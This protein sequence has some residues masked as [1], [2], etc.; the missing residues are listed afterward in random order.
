MLKE[1][2][3]VSD[4]LAEAERDSRSGMA[5]TEPGEGTGTEG[6]VRGSHR[7]FR[8]HTADNTPSEDRSETVN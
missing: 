5:G 2:S 6:G 7:C 1:P 4:D 3:T 8:S